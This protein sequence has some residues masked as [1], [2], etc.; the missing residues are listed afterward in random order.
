MT[1]AGGKNSILDK[2]ARMVDLN[3]EDANPA[4]DIIKAR[5]NELETPLLVLYLFGPRISEQLDNECPLVGYGVLFP[6][7][8]NEVKV[9]YVARPM[10]FDDEDTQVDD[11][12]DSDDE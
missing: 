8:Q 1:V 2:R 7:F 3:L 9:E 6:A 12:P 5:R 11:D 4:E 10:P